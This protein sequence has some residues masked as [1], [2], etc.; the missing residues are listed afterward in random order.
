MADLLSGG[1]P[2]D[3]AEVRGHP[4]FA[5]INWDD[6]L[7][8][9]IPAPFVPRIASPTD[10]SNF[11]EEFTNME[12]VD[13]PG[14]I[15]DSAE[16]VFRGY[17]FVAPSIIFA[18][19]NV[20]SDELF[21]RRKC[22]TGERPSN[23]LPNP[24][25][26]PSTSNLVGCILQNSPFFQRYDLD[27]R[28]RVLGDGAFSVCRRCVDRKTGKE[29]AVKIVSKRVDC[30]KEIALLKTC[31]GHP[32]IVKLVDVIQVSPVIIPTH[33]QMARPLNRPCELP[34]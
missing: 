29:F 10:V 21:F 33:H 14:D 17:S 27:L 28:E 7:L 19:N 31:Q 26:R 22:R 11:S 16:H 32:N 25:K 15:P 18:E 3:A 5:S 4:F 20:L 6:L 34:V 13:A 23:I 30:S 9:N 12:A 2:E 8:K 24:D 1:G